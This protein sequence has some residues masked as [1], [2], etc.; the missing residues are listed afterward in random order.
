MIGSA[1][2]AREVIP[3]MLQNNYVEAIDEIKTKKGKRQKRICVRGIG[4]G[5][6]INISSTPAIA[7][8]TKGFPYTIAKAANIALAKCIS[9]E[10]G[11][12]NIRAYSLALGNIAF[13]SYCKIFGL[14]GLIFGHNI[15]YSLEGDKKLISS[16]HPSKRNTNTGTLTWD[17]W[18]DA[19][20]NAR[21]LIKS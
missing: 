3:I 14:K 21:S 20:R 18:I 12:N 17:V 1:R 8:H 6:I 15:I 2:L 4:R 16:Y 7:G 5:V 19:F 9:K 10:Y 11:P 13:D